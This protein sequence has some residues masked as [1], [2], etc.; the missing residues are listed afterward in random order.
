M[1]QRLS[2][3]SLILLP[4]VLGCLLG[5]LGTALWVYYAP[6]LKTP[7]PIEGHVPYVV[8]VQK[9]W[10][11]LP[12]T[13]KLQDDLQKTLEQYHQEFSKT[14][15]EL[16]AEDQALFSLQKGTMS[17]QESQALENRKSLFYEKAAQTQKDVETKQKSISQRHSSA[18]E[19][20][21]A[22]IQEK[23]KEVAQQE[24][25]ELILSAHNAIYVDPQRDVT[26]KVYEKVKDA[27]INFDMQRA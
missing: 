4:V 20:L 21:H 16:K 17:A 2:K 11:D 23:V 19:K 25:I 15:K 9:I 1:F 24:N 13:K 22:I 12:A 3:N 6:A 8:N 5:Y 10:D 7:V 14:E 27:T 18:T 26:A